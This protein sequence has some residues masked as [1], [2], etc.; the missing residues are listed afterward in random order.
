MKIQKLKSTPQLEGRIPELRD[1][2]KPEKEA[3]KEPVKKV[4]PVRVFAEAV[5]QDIPEPKEWKCF[6]CKSTESWQRPLDLRPICD[7]C[8]PNPERNNNNESKHISQPPSILNQY[9]GD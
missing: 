5:R 7:R 3:Q 9:G 4:R 6:W 8:H 1:S 2:K